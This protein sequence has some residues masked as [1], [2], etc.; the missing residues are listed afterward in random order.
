M[1]A[2]VLWQ[3]QLSSY[4]KEGRFTLTADSN[5]QMF[6]TKAIV[7]TEVS[8]DVKIDVIV[9][10]EKDCTESPIQMIWEHKLQNNVNLIYVPILANAL[11]TRFDFPFSHMVSALPDLHKYTHVYVNDPMLLR[12]YKALF[13]L[14][15]A[16]PKFVV[17]T[18][19]LDSPVARIAPDEVSY[20]H[21]TVEAV[22]KSDVCL[23]HCDSMYQVFLE[24]IEK[25]YKQE[26][27]RDMVAKKSKVWKDGYSI[28]E[29]RKPVEMKN[30]RFD[31]ATL[32][33]KTV[34]WVP[35]RVGGLGKSFDYTNNGKFL[36]ESVPELWKRRQDFVV[37]AGNPNQKILN[38]EIA[39]LC[40]AYVKLV[41]TAFNRDEYRWMSQRA[42]VT[43]GLYTNDT[44]GGLASLEA[45]EFHA[46]PLFPDVYEYKVYFDAVDW[47][48]AFRISPDLSDIVDV[49]SDVIDRA[50]SKYDAK[51]LRKFVREYA[52][53]EYTTPRMM[54]QL[55]ML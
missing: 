54:Q 19:F 35:N 50:K 9:P 44:N 3:L 22:T 26:F 5:W 4:T 25:H 34:V 48:K 2:Y 45:I 14:Q 51:A 17:Q 12:H 21:G 55:G 42:D 47:P 52:A 49:A 43:V 32:E 46:I 30:L 18:H 15:K 39:E 10:P 16:A 38:N 28:S 27:Y 24:A 8:P 41:D 7:M 23:W 31:P 11:A 13:F 29:I 20:W 53:Y 33:G 36:F 40:P 1:S 6:L 37:V